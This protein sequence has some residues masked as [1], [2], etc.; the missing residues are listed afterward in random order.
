MSV[1]WKQYPEDSSYLLVTWKEQLMI[2]VENIYFHEK[3]SSVAILIL[4]SESKNL[5][6]DKIMHKAQFS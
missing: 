1:K 5:C 2:L 3:I 4:Q 6:R